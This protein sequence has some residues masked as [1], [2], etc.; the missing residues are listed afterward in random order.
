MLVQIATFMETP[1]ESEEG[2]RH[3]REE[4][5]PSIRGA[6]G[7]NSAY[8]VVDRENGKRLSIM[9]WDSADAAAAAMPAVVASIQ[10]RRAE[11]GLSEPQASP[12]SVER[13]EVVSSC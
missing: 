2:V 11:A 3:V 1:E 10:Q 12:A 9:I 13:F 5:E 4:V 7:L 8:W 6:A